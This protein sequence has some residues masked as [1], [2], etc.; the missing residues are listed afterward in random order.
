MSNTS[1]YSNITFPTPD[2]KILS[3]AN[4]TSSIDNKNTYSKMFHEE[5]EIKLFYEGSSTLIID[6]NTIVTDPGDIVIINP[7]EF[8]S[9]VE[10]GDTK[11]RYHLIMIGL[12]FFENIV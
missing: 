10:L 8:H 12:D 1:F 2:F 6:N 9:T 7:Y 4:V 5:I 3:I 11:G